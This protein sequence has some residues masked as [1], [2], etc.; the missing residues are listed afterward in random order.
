MVTAELYRAQPT[1][2]SL[3]QSMPRADSDWN[4]DTIRRLRALWAEGHSTAEIGRRLGITKN[5]VVGKSRRLGLPARPPPIRRDRIEHAPPPRRLRGPTLPD[6]QSLLRPATTQQTPTHT[7]RA[8]AALPARLPAAVAVR[9][10]PLGK[11]PCCWPIGEPGTASF[12]LCDVPNEPGKPYCRDH[13][14]VAYRKV[15]EHEN[16]A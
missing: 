6:L 13:C 10:A 14:L 11:D 15:R 12:R 2:Q 7:A 8:P 3:E 16:A 1:H 9:I 4:G 5:A